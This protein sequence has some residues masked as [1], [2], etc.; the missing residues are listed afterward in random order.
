MNTNYWK[1]FSAALGLCFVFLF[2]LM[3][4]QAAKND[5]I[6]NDVEHSKQKLNY[7]EKTFRLS[8]LYDGYKLD[9]LIVF[10]SAGLRK[11]LSSFI[12][13]NSSVLVCVFSD[14]YCKDCVNKAINDLRRFA[15]V[16]SDSSRIF[17]L[18][19][20]GTYRAFNL[21]KKN[22]SIQDFN[23]LLIVDMHFPLDYAIDEPYYFMIDKDLT[24]SNVFV[25]S[26]YF[27][28][29]TKTYFDIVTELFNNKG[30]ETH[31]N[32]KESRKPKP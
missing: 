28:E 26:I 12:S 7:F 31:E 5:L 3:K 14:N 32:S 27:P 18:C 24:V 9:H 16:Q 4:N 22:H 8:Q 21:G 6:L 2:F 10:D 15:A 20:S 13:Q 11:D 1:I 29:V 25:P 23:A 30:G 19:S 17:F